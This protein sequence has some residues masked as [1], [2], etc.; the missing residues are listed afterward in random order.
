MLITPPDRL[1][2]SYDIPVLYV[3]VLRVR[4]AFFHSGK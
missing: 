3:S 2:P 4:Q 1:G